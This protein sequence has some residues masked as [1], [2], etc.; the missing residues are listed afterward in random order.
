MKT[1]L[2]E[3]TFPLGETLITR[4]AQNVLRYLDVNAALARHEKCDWGDLCDEDWARNNSAVKNDGGR[5]FSAYRYFRD[6]K[7]WII[8]EADRSYTTVMLPEDY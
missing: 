8:T 7:F 1:I 6:V 2:A 3:K 4:N 5:I